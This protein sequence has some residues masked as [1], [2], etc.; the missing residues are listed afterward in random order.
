VAAAGCNV[1]AIMGTRILGNMRE[2]IIASTLVAL[3]PCSART[4]VIL[5]AVSLTAGWQ[6]A[7][8]VYAVTFAVMLLT[9]IGL[10]RLLPGEGTGLVMEMFPFRR[11]GLRSMLKKT[12]V[13]F[14][15]F[16]VVATPIIV[17]GSIVLG[18]LYETG[19]LWPLAAPLRPIME[20]WLGI[21][22]VAGLTLIVAVL[23]KELALQL[24]VTLAMIQYGPQASNLLAFMRPD[25]IVVYALVNT[26]YVPCIA[27]VAILGRELG[28]R[29]ALLISGFTIALALL[30]GGAARPI[31]HFLL[32]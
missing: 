1:P 12:W 16:A 21:P 19:L 5:G 13:R 24:L 26:I 20:G 32:G 17:G 23:R 29:R 28:W 27:T 10:H 11:P 31:A 30:V 14:H 22:A 15:H 25:Q 6:A 18:G 2:R 8:G 7:L 3:T 4:A 9:G